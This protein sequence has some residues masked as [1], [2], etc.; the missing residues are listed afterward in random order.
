MYSADLMELQRMLD[1]ENQNH[2]V[3]SETFYKTMSEWTIKIKSDL[4][5]VSEDSFH[6]ATSR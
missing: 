3:N 1:P 5:E 6:E 4:M 2:S